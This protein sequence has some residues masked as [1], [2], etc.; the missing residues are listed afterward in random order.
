MRKSITIDENKKYIFPKNIKK[1]YYKDIFL[2]ISPETA[3]WIILQNNAQLRFFEL[4]KYLDLKS[5]CKK[6][7]FKKEDIIQVLVQIEAKQFC[8]TKVLSS[9]AGKESIHFYLTNACNLRCPHCYMFSDVKK[10]NEL[11][12][13]EICLFL[14][15]YKENNGHKVVFSGGEIS[16]RKDLFYIC[17][18]AHN[19]GLKVQLL[20][21]GVLWTSKSIE[22]IA[23]FIDEVQIS[24]D[25]YSEETNALIR[26][27]GNFQ[28]ALNSVDLFIKNKVSTE[29]GITPFFNE[30]LQSNY[31]HYAEFA[32]SLI[33]KYR[34][35]IQV[36]FAAEMLEGRNVCLT[37]IEHNEY[38]DI[39]HKIYSVYYEGNMSLYPFVSMRRQ[40]RIM[41]N[42]IF[43]TLAISSVGDVYMC[44]RIASVGSVAN[45]RKDNMDKIMKIS[46]HSKDLS[47]INNL[48]P[49]NICELKYICGGGCRID[50]FNKLAKSTNIL[51][52]QSKDIPPRKCSI[53]YKEAFYD[54]MIETN[55]LIFQ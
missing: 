14:E 40:H 6:E 26:G 29:I 48:K 10:E 32:K 25:G 17:K 46:S 49:C 31:H 24:I 47:N 27:K 45:I 9:T 54:L 36:R 3:N 19:I 8:N 43:G 1:V 51:S 2:I 55:D 22:E 13:E 28:K 12:T 20:T 34:D 7:D 44:S 38:T 15:K 11:T 42:C 23:P 39:I 35:K 30:E 21:N 52:L 41:D 18:H 5:A 50:Y 16:L 53:K 33:Q 4:L 37:S